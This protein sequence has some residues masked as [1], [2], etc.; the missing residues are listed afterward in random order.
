MLDGSAGPQSH[1]QDRKYKWGHNKTN[2]LVR[3]KQP[4]GDL[5]QKV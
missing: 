5:T 4:V 2:K 1:N 3:S